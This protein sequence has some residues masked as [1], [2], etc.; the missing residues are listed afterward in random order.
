MNPGVESKLLSTARVLVVILPLCFIVGRVAVD[1]AL[2]LTAILFLVRSTM[3][4]DWQWLHGAWFK[5]GAALWLWMLI[6]SP[7]ALDPHLSFSQAV[8]WIRFLIFAAALE[9]W[10]LN[11]VWMRR[12]LWVATGVVVFV[13]CDTWLQY[14]TGSD[15]FGHA[16]PTM[17]RLSGPFDNLMP[18]IFITKMMFPAVLGALVWHAWQRAWAKGALLS[19]ILL[20]V[21]AIFISGERMA[22]LLALMGLG[23]AALLQR[24]MLRGLLVSSLGLVGVG[25]VV[26]SLIDPNMIVRH[27]TETE[28]TVKSLHDSPY[29]EIWRS[30]LHLT[31]ERPLFGVGMK[32][33][34]VACKDPVLGLP[35]NVEWRCATHT[36]NLYLEF[37]T[38][39]GVPGFLGFVL[40]A[41]VWLRKLWRAWRVEPRN[42]WLLG[43][44][45]AVV[46][47]LWPLGPSASF[48]SN[49]LGVTFWLSLGWA[50]AAARMR[51]TVLQKDAT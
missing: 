25:I 29:G 6:I 42:E 34:R 33:F 45:V 13:A 17:K 26:L 51:P 49:W 8:P 27:V 38:E 15:V 23:V 20:F 36:H 28:E 32:N 10:V 22:L 41:I 46:I 5:V 44:L 14:L 4:R 3:A 35:E 39:A 2:T 40:L 30:A 7:F 24:G 43:P 48:F 37:L 47:L 16:R 21:G 31:S 19:L 11:E 50:L 9:A 12:L 1:A 18:G